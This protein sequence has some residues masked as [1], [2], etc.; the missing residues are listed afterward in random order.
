MANHYLK[1]CVST[2]TDRETVTFHVLNVI[3]LEP[4]DHIQI[5]VNGVTALVLNGIVPNRAATIKSG[6]ADLS[7]SGLSMLPPLPAS[8]AQPDRCLCAVSTRPPI[9]YMRTLIH[10]CASLFRGRFRKRSS[11]HGK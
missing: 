4:K 5:T 8:R 2:V 1:I 9:L 11:E 7:N 3:S 10:W 6:K